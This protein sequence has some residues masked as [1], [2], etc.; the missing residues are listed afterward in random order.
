MIDRAV[1]GT[2]GFRFGQVRDI[3]GVDFLPGGAK[4]DDLPGMLA[5]A[6]PAELFLAGEG[7]RPSIVQAAY[8]A[9]G[10]SEKLTV[11]NSPAARTSKAAITWLLRDTE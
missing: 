4:Y 9:A 2:A 11:D 7:K 6:A 5:V 10:G 8:K 1:I 3:H